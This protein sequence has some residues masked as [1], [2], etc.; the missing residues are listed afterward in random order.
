VDR[1]RRRRVRSEARSHPRRSHASTRRVSPTYGIDERSD[2][3]LVDRRRRSSARCRSRAARVF[4]VDVARHAVIET[5]IVSL[6]E[7]VRASP[8]PLVA[9]R[10]SCLSPGRFRR[11]AGPR[12]TLRCFTSTPTGSD[13]ACSIAARAWPSRRC[14]PGRHER[15]QLSAVSQLRA[16]AGWSTRECLRGQ[17]VSTSTGLT[18][19]GGATRAG[20]IHPHTR[21]GRAEIQ[22]KRTMRQSPTGPDALVI[23]DPSGNLGSQWSLGPVSRTSAQQ[24]R[25]WRCGGS[26]SPDQ[27][28]VVALAPAGSRARSAPQ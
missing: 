25:R 22:P 24:G 17:T 3:A 12:W 20:H 10:A 9:Y 26:L 4:G 28:I 15:D 14:L 21:R 5:V 27:G 1:A 7:A 2:R 13:G 16:E 18:T 19:A 11:S 6:S 8:G 23:G